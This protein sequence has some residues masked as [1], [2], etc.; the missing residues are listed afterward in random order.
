MIKIKMEINEKLWKVNFRA[1]IRMM[2]MGYTCMTICLLDMM[3]AVI[4]SKSSPFLIFSMVVCFVT[5]MFDFYKAFKFSKAA[6][7]YESE[8]EEQILEFLAD[9]PEIISIVEGIE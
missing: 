3:I 6:K 7:K 5:G 1:S 8:I 2:N 9:H 4:A